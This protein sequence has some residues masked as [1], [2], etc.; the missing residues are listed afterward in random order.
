MI[1]A[2]LQEESCLNYELDL[3]MTVRSRT[4]PRHICLTLTPGEHLQ[5]KPL[6][7]FLVPP[8]YLPPPGLGFRI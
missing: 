6:V 4:V 2:E 3:S 5:V 7:K 8:L 1:K